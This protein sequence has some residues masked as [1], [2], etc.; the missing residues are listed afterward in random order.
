MKNLQAY[1]WVRGAG[2]PRGR[3][4]GAILTADGAKEEGQITH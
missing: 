3:G 4:W 2:R 1:V